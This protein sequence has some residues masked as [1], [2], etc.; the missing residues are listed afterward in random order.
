[1]ARALNIVTKIR[2]LAAIS[3]FN[4]LLKFSVEGSPR[5]ARLVLTDGRS[6]QPFFSTILPLHLM[7]L[8]DVIMK[9]LVSTPEV[10][11]PSTPEGVQTK[12]YH[13]T[14]NAY[15][16]EN[17]N[18]HVQQTRPQWNSLPHNET[19]VRDPCWHTWT[20]GNLDKT[21]RSLSPFAPVRCHH[22]TPLIQRKRGLGG[23]S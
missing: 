8:P 19:M 13:L 14:A 21:F 7:V 2:P 16:L 17:K 4:S 18:H 1:M 11:M 12:Q 23:I 20:P 22:T 9:E 3:W 5:W 10:I 6:Y 15:T